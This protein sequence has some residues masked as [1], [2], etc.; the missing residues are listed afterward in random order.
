MTAAKAQARLNQLDNL[1]GEPEQER[2][3][4][5]HYYSLAPNASGYVLDKLAAEERQELIDAIARGEA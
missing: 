3:N 1:A 5:H 2:K 4:L